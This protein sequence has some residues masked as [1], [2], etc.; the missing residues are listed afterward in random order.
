MKTSSNKRLT[1]AIHITAV[2][3]VA[4]VNNVRVYYHCRNE[5]K[6]ARD[7]NDLPSGHYCDF[8]SSVWINFSHLRYINKKMHFW[9]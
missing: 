7:Y 9:Y 1:S 3:I 5:P 4:D 8:F 2:L 6:Y